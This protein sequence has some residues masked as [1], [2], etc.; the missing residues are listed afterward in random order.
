MIKNNKGVTIMSLVITI[1]VMVILISIVG[2]FSIDSIKNSY[3]S[4]EKKEMADL[5]EYVL[6]RKAKLLNDEFNVSGYELVTDEFLNWFANGL[7]ETEKQKIIEV[8]T[9]IYLNENY[10][11]FYITKD[12]LNNES[13]TQEYI[14]V[15]DIKN[16]Y[17]INFYTGTIIGLYDNGERIEIS[18]TIKNLEEIELE[19]Y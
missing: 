5:Q 4:N 16:N 19:L 6:S 17:I 1:V 14:I 18:G 12:K 2:Y 15:K 7:A 3:I 10:K 9:D 13:P 8:N 11:Y